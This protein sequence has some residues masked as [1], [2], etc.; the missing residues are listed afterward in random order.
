MRHGI[1]VHSALKDKWLLFCCRSAQEKARWLESFEE[2]RR[3]VAQDLRDGLEFAP[4]AR[5]LARMSAARCYQRRP[6]SKPRSKS[7]IQVAQHLY[8]I[9]NTPVGITLI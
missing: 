5:H 1:K 9:W 4:A 7:G 6:P 3:L 2:E 8:T